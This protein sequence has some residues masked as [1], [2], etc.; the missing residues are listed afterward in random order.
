MNAPA[1]R[2]VLDA[3]VRRSAGGRLLT[4]GTPPRMVR[5][6][7]AGAVALDGLLD[8]R[9]LP[10]GEPL[11]ERLRAS[12]LLHPLPRSGLGAEVGFV[13]PLRDG[14]PQVAELV[15]ALRREGA[16]IVVDDRS[17][18]GS[19]ELARRAGARVLANRGAPGPAGARNT[20]LAASTA[21]FVAF[22][23]ADCHC[24][25]EWAAPLAALLAEDPGLAMIAPRVRSAPGADAVG[26]Y[27]RAASP[28]DMGARPSLVGPGR[29]IPYV[30]SAALVARRAA[31]LE[32]GGFEESL[33]FGEDVDLVFRAVAAGWSVRY[34]PAV[35]VLHRPRA[36]A[37]ALARQRYEYGGSAAALD[38]R[39]PTAVAPLRVHPHSAAVWA[40]AAL[41]GAPAAAA[42]TAVSV[43]VAAARGS[44]GAARR[45]LAL[46]ALRGH[47][48]AN[49]ALA[50]ALVRDWLPLTLLA[51]V[52]S[53]RL[54]RAAL[55]A[56]VVDAAPVVLA[57]PR[58]GAPAVALRALDNAAYCA[59]LWRGA[60]GRRS[61]AA[62][63][64]RAQRRGAGR[65]AT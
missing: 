29:R 35:E 43:T 30:P 4:G 61:L 55:G 13:I 11:A 22:L 19:P 14:G 18:D 59:G 49:R 6:G 41:G 46:L 44:D 25:G 40:A 28:L 48:E 21:P 62:L 34:S 3:G 60:A 50:R 23:D 31:L 9:R 47:L 33:R 39:H 32:L 38:Q 57:D 15:A 54:R 56:A 27:E 12:G 16:V 24:P 37:A 53:R 51:A 2:Y 64:P 58:R 26:R 17:S 5:L 1:E 52:R 10:G 45:A 7:A 8:G 63:L 42:A 65:S 20:G 36:S